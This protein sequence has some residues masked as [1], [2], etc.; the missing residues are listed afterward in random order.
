MKSRGDWSDDYTPP[1][2]YYPEGIETPK[3]IK[4]LIPIMQKYGYKDS[5]IAKV[6]GENLLRI[7]KEVW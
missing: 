1:P 5:D 6:M 4:N 2:H 7:Y 3:K